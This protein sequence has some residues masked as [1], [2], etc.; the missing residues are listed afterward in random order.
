MERKKENEEEGEL[1]E[2]EEEV[3]YGEKIRKVCLWDQL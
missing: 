2:E 1:K 3:R